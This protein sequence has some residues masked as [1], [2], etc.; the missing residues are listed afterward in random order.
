MKALSQEEFHRVLGILSSN[1]C[2]PQQAQAIQ[3]ALLFSFEAFSDSRRSTFR[4]GQNV[5][6]RDP[7]TGKSE[8][9]R[10]IRVSRKTVTVFIT[11]WRTVRATHNLVTVL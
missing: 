7:R 1:Q 5:S 8:T 6:V 3:N 11:E 4:K 9:G 2:D 10:I